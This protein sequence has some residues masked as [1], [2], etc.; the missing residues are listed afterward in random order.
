V[1]G[2]TISTHGQ[3]SPGVAI[4]EPDCASGALF[5]RASQGASVLRRHAMKHLIILLMVVVAGNAGLRSKW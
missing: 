5:P 4:G 2:F 3:K 1:Y